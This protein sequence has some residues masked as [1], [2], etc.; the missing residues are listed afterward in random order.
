MA[1]LEI[2]PAGK[3]DVEAMWRLARQPAVVAGTLQI[4][5]LRLAQREERFA[6]LSDDDHFY[7]AVRHGEVVGMADLHAHGRPRRRHAGE[8]G[9]A[10]SPAH[11]RQGI[12][13]ALIRTLV[14]LADNWLDL[15]RLELTVYADNAAAVRLYEK[16]GFEVEGRLREYAFTDGAYLDAL[17]MARVRPK[18]SDVPVPARTETSDDPDP[19]AGIGSSESAP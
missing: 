11:S 13:S 1:E 3:D 12:G 4:P 10:V 16:H 9:V 5:S 14:E 2:R 15:R 7:V 8:I 19:Q 18:R 17:Y 6:Q